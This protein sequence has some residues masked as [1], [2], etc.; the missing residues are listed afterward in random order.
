MNKDTY[1][2]LN[3]ISPV[4]EYLLFL[5]RIKFFNHNELTRADLLTNFFQIRGSSFFKNGLAMKT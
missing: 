1:C 3:L 5:M 2:L 4:S